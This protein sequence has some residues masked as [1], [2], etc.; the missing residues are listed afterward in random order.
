MTYIELVNEVL[1]RLRENPVN[2]ITETVEGELVAKLVSDAYKVVE[3]AHDWSVLRDI[4]TEDTV[5]AQDTIELDGVP[6]DSKVFFAYINGE[7]ELRQ[8]SKEWLM[9]RRLL[10]TMNNDEPR[11]YSITKANLADQDLI[12]T[13]YPTP[14]AVYTISFDVAKRGTAPT[15]DGDII[16]VP[17]DP[18]LQMA[19][20]FTTRERGETGG[21]SAS[22]YFQ[23]AQ[24]SLAA[25]IIRDANQRPD[26]IT[27][28]AP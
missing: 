16:Q 6:V 10:N 28:Y 18:V 20:G 12:V 7:H 23:L 21:T 22:E 27:M 3:D 2:T 9:R 15:Q 8:V 13:L 17:V 14:D 5:A 24:I 26:E 19:L 4:H 1:V 11:Y 25:A